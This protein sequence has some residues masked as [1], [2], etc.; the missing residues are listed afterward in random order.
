MGYK[1]FSGDSLKQYYINDALI[2]SI[3]CLTAALF[4]C[5]VSI[6]AKN[7]VFTFFI[8]FVFIVCPYFISVFFHGS[9]F[10]YAFTANQ[11]GAMYS[12]DLNIY[13]L[14]VTYILKA[15]LYSGFCIR[16]WGKLQ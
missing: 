16:K 5:A 6:F 11:L 4:I 13:A 9:W 14:S 1:A 8:S 2:K 12:E 15:S 3:S 10:E 7:T